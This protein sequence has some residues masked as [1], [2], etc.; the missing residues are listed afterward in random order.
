VL[1]L[2]RAEVDRCLARWLLDGAT[3]LVNRAI[4]C[5][6]AYAHGIIAIGLPVDLATQ[7]TAQ[8][9][10]LVLVLLLRRW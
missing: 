3:E 10:D 1:G 2:A 8:S 5:V 7:V 9:E 4:F 6:G